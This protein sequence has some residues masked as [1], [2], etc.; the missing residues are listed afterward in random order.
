MKNEPEMAPICKSQAID[1][2]NCYKNLYS[3]IKKINPKGAQ[4]F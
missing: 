1:Y 4:Q 3:S 2:E